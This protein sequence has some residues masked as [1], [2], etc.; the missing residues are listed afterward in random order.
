MRILSGTAVAAALLSPLMAQSNTIPGVDGRLTNA[1]SPITFGRRG[2]AYPNGEVAM[3]CSYTMCNPGT[4]NIAWTAPMS[5]NHP[6]FAWSVVRAANGRM[7]QITNNATTYVKHAFAAANSA[8]TCGGTCQSS[9]SGGLRVNC[10]DTYGASTNG[11][12]FYLG[13]APEIDPWTGIWLPVGSYFDRGDPD[14]GAPLNTDGVRS[15]QS[16]S[17]GFPTDPV[18]NRITLREQDLVQTGTLYYCTHIVVPGEDGDLHWDNAGSRQMTATWNG[19]AWTFAVPGSLVQGSVLNQW[20][21]ASVTNGRNGDDDGHFVVAVKVTPLGGGLHHYEYAVENFDNARGGATLRVPVC[22]T[23]SVTNITFR[24]TNGDPLDNWTA[25]RIGAE[26]VFQAPGNNP[27]DWNNIYNFGFDCDIA[28]EAGPVNID[29][30]RI[31]PGALTVGVATQVPSGLASVANLGPGCGAPAPVLAANSLP[32]IPSP[33][34]GLTISVAPSAAVGVF[35][36]FGAGNTLLAP[37]CVAY[38]ADPIVP[39]GVFVADGSGLAVAPWAIVNDV[40]MEG[41][42]IDW[43]AAELVTGGPLWGFLA[44]SNGL[45]I[46]IA[47]R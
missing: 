29:Q 44:L 38:L 25:S 36:S 16:N 30:A 26:L 12:R 20:A 2:P 1:A 4:V 33:G 42:V 7:E 22:P 17:G 43:Q 24:D 19:S 21:G 18:K 27:L 37:G 34:F 5:P 47:T 6:F 31:G 28:P 15:L 3:A 45:E 41:L 13:P 23:T 9:P 32:T 14:V 35:A 39:Y 46:L 40:S 10:T 11:S 8:S